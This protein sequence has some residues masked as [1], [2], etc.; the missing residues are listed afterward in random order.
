MAVLFNAVKYLHEMDVAH[1]DVKP[2]NLLLV[3][4]ADDAPIKLA[5]F[6]FARPVGEKGLETQCGTPG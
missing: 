3:S 1:R 6:G 5:D 4:E 2:E